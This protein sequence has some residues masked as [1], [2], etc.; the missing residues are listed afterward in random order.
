MLSGKAPHQAKRITKKEREENR[1]LFGKHEPVCDLLPQETNLAKFLK[2][3]KIT[4]NIIGESRDGQTAGNRDVQVLGPVRKKKP[5][6]SL[7]PFTPEIMGFNH[8]H[9]R[10]KKE[11]EEK[12]NNFVSRG[13]LKSV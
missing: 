8:G 12:A 3:K 2:K 7:P 13:T 9:R 11:Q 5:K 10:S 1:I 4:R 6:S